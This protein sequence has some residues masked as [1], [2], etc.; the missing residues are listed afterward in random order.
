M[1]D[2]GKEVSLGGRG[3]ER[4][5]EQRGRDRKGASSNDKRQASVRV[6]GEVESE[7]AGTRTLTTAPHDTE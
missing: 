4:R 1:T 3:R 5:E 2:Q 6:G 7:H